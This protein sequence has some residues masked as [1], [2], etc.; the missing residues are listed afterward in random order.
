MLAR[1]L[2]PE[3]RTS[4]LSVCCSKVSTT[5]EIPP[6]LMIAIWFSKLLPFMLASQVQHL[7]CTIVLLE[8]CTMWKV[9]ATAVAVVPSRRESTQS[10]CP[11]PLQLSLPHSFSLSLSLPAFSKEVGGTTSQHQRVF[12]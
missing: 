5:C 6:A 7:S 4:G 3:D 2:Q 10:A 8:L 9:V 12:K 1:A 11:S